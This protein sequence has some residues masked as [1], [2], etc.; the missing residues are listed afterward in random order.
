MDYSPKPP[1]ESSKG[2]REPLAGARVLDVVQAAKGDLS[3][4]VELM[5]AVEA[6]CP[7]WPAREPSAG[8]GYNVY[9]L[10]EKNKHAIKPRTWSGLLQAA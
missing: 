7:V 8:N 2:V 5:A 6:L 4:W 1:A 3:D 10:V 9:K